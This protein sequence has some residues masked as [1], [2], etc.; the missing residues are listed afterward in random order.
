MPY[1]T[2]PLDLTRP[3]FTTFNPSFSALVMLF[4]RF[5]GLVVLFS[6]TSVITAD[7][8]DIR[9]PIGTFRGASVA[10]SGVDK[11]LGIPYAQP[12]IGEL[13]FKAPQPIT[14]HS[15]ELKNATAFGNACPQRPG[16]L[17]APLSEDCLFLNVR[18]SMVIP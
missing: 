5:R 10:G 2:L 6:L 15:S 16:D 3:L 1:V 13:R 17:G 4:R 9:L 11:W 7:N 14:Q 18:Q 12:P 8:L